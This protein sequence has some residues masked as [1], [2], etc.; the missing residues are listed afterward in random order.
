MQPAVSSLYPLKIVADIS[1][2]SRLPTQCRVSAESADTTTVAV[3][4]PP[5]LRG[6]DTQSIIFY[7]QYSVLQSNY[8]VVGSWNLDERVCGVGGYDTHDDDGA[9]LVM[10]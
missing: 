9:F 8:D 2:C 7:C 5:T 1:H 10:A 3:T 6:S 4:T